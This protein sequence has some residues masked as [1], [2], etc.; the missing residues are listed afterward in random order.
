MPTL[1][2]QLTER[3]E[4]LTERVA[5]LVDGLELVVLRLEQGRDRVRITLQGRRDPL[6]WAGTRALRVAHLQ[7]CTRR[8]G[9]GAVPPLEGDARV[10]GDAWAWWRD[11]VVL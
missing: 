4:A 2:V 10:I 5:E 8:G 11:G 9:G 1:R 7:A 3:G 6:V